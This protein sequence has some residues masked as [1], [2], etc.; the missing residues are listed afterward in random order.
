MGYSG[1]IRPLKE[2]RTHRETETNREEDHVMT[3]LTEAAAS[4][5]VPRIA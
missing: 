3:R 2:E 4:Q 5:G 1:L